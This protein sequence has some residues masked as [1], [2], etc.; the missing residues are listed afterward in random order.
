MYKK[1]PVTQADPN[2][3]KIYVP[4]IQKSPKKVILRPKSP[5]II[6]KPSRNI[7]SPNS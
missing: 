3:P 5:K 2:P 6:E 1:Q 7:P 4:R